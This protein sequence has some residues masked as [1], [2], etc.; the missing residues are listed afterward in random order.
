MATPVLSIVMS[1]FNAEA[2]IKNA[3]DSILN[4]TFTNY[5]L[6]VINDGS[7]DNTASILN[8]Y[9]DSRIVITTQHNKG[10]V[11]S[12]KTGIKIAQGKYIARQDADDM[13]EPTRLEKQ[14]K[15]LED[16]A[17]VII[18]GCSIK[19]MN[20]SGKITHQHHVLINSPE[21]KQE[22]LLRSPFAHGSVMMRR[23]AYLESG[24]YHDA[25]WPAEDY[26][27]WLR[28]SPLG[29]F[30]NIDEPLYIYRENKKGIS[31]TN[32]GLQTQKVIKIQDEAWEQKTRLLR[33]GRINLTYYLDLENSH[34]RIERIIRTNAWISRKSIACLDAVTAIRA[35]GTIYSNKV[36]YTKLA[37][38][39]KRR[40][41]KHI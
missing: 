37:G 22:L 35:A 27:L 13:S 2:Y 6:I 39:L 41:K 5:E 38:K 28:M 32:S 33:S 21:L 30:K 18:V 24:G 10:L 15:V 9:K 19:V 14:V 12:L 8:Q 40:I 26:G 23:D 36:T 31:S 16:T 25:D 7:T 34:E 4:Q 29:D 11:A 20:M 1:V 17:G 3:I